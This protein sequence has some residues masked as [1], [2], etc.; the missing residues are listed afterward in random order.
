MLIRRERFLESWVLRRETQKDRGW[1]AGQVGTR[2]SFLAQG[3]H[4]EKRAAKRGRKNRQSWG[5]NCIVL[6]FHFIT[7]VVV[8]PG[9][10]SCQDAS[11][12][13]YITPGC[14]CAWP[15]QYS[16]NRVDKRPLGAGLLGPVSFTGVLCRALAQ[17][18]KGDS[19]AHERTALLSSLSIPVVC[20]GSR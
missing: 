4:D 13:I 6:P 5:E 19:L 7:P 18:S 10:N 2:R 20:M 12:T 1:L 3:Q 11:S 15:L 16:L 8:I 17:V 14:S 9:L